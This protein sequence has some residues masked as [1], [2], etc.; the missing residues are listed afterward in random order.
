MR[1]QRKTISSFLT[2]LMPFKKNGINAE[3]TTD[4]IFRAGIVKDLHVT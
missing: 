3:E 2:F 1:F 4:L